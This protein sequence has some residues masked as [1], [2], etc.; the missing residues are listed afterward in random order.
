MSDQLPDT[1]ACDPYDAT[2][3]PGSY[4]YRPSLGWGIAFTLLFAAIAVGQTYHMF[5]TKAFWTFVFIV[6]A[7]LEVIGWVGRTIS[8]QCP[9]YRTTFLMQTATL[10]MGMLSTSSYL[11]L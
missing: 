2:L 3:N 8:Y 11:I 7:I 5:R 10:I 9:Y 1:P 6:G 4:G